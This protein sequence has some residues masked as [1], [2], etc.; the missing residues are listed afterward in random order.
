MEARGINYY[1]FGAALEKL[2]EDPDRLAI[3]RKKYLKDGIVIREYIPTPTNTTFGPRAALIFENEDGPLG[4]W[5]PNQEDIHSMNWIVLHKVEDYG[6]D[7]DPQDL[8]E[9]DFVESVREIYI[10]DLTRAVNELC[11]AI[12]DFAHEK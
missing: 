8:E 6:V 11:K 5:C 4:H 9:D 2:Q 10:K 1:T 7:E 3:S 12:V